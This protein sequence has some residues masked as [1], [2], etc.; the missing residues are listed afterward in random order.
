MIVDFH[1]HVLPPMVRDNR[2]RY[3]EKDAAFA[4]IYKEAKAAIVTAEDLIDSMDR[5]EI[6]ITVIVNYSWST[7]DMCRET[8]DYILETCARYPDRIAGFCAT[9]DLT[10][11]ESLREIERCASGGARGIGELRPDFYPD[12]FSDRT[13]TAPF[14]NL[15][16]QHNLLLLLHTS[17]PVGHQYPG[18]GKAVPGLIYSFLSDFPDITTICAHWGG[19]LPFYNLMPE[20]HELFINTYFDTA[21]SPFLYRPGIYEQVVRLAGAEK[22]LFG[23]DYPVMSPQQILNEIIAADITQPEREQILGGNGRLLL[24]R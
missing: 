7:A 14:A 18:K 17:E 19:G 15:L 11:D 2:S 16:R 23:S 21:A 8:N 13:A 1:A 5:H 10:S 22:V 6:D 20:A 4:S 12:V 3:V 24:G 9:A